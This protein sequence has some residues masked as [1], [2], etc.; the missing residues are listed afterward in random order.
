M[1]LV[2]LS[3]LERITFDLNTKQNYTVMTVRSNAM[4]YM[5][6]NK[7]IKTSKCFYFKFALSGLMQMSQRH[8]ISNG[9][10]DPECRDDVT[11]IC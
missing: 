1:Q 4:H 6:L 2:F 10:H 5:T 8:C 11:W 7:S 3:H 9:R